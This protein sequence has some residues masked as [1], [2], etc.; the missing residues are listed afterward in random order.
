MV[1]AFYHYR[2]A[3]IAQE[4]Q[5]AILLRSNAYACNTLMLAEETRFTGSHPR[6]RHRV[7]MDQSC[8]TLALAN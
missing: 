7:L 2:G 4:W 1:K 8:W 5:M 6:A 3:V